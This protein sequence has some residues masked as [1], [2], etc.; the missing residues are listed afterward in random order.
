MRLVPRLGF[1]SFSLS[2]G[3]VCHTVSLSL[4]LS[5]YFRAALIANCQAMLSSRVESSRD[6]SVSFI[7]AVLV[8]LLDI[9]LCARQLCRVPCAVPCRT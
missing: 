4:A 2:R 3:L 1:L 6:G 7:L 8:Y 5:V 9:G